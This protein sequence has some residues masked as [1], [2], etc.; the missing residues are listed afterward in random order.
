MKTKRYKQIV[1]PVMIICILIILSCSTI[2]STARNGN[3]WDLQK[4]LTDGVN[5]NALDDKGFTPLMIAAENGQISNVAFLIK[6]GADVNFKS[7]D[8]YT[9]LIL[10]AVSGNKEIIEILLN[11][12]ARQFDQTAAGAA[13][14]KWVDVSIQLY[15]LKLGIFLG[16]GDFKENIAKKQKYVYTLREL[17]AIID[18]LTTK[19]YPLSEFEKYFIVKKI[20]DKNAEFQSVGTAEYIG[21][22]NMPDFL[23]Y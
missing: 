12:G 5:I 16:K 14:S 3:T 8:N 18:F 21:T 13:A 10:A 20:K 19:G 23:N 15:I 17:E 9:A 6:K 4:F 1:L 2:H 22:I 7:K 11:N